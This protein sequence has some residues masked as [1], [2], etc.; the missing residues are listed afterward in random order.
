MQK[1]IP[2]PSDDQEQHRK[3]EAAIREALNNSGHFSL[4][5]L[6]CEFDGK[7]ITLRG[8]VS[9]FYEKQIAQQ[10]V[11]SRIEGAVCFDNQL[12]VAI[13]QQRN[14]AAVSD[15]DSGSRAVTQPIASFT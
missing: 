5:R 2:K 11:L 9:T 3:V 7:V 12:E 15:L 13:G 14:K 1:S 4:R 6:V 8:R 10:I